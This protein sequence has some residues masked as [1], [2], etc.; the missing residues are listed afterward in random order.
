MRSSA[1]SVSR[2]LSSAGRYAILFAALTVADRAMA[3]QDNYVSATRGKALA[4]AGDC[5]ACH[6]AP[7]GKPFAGGLS[8]ATPFGAIMTPNLTPDEA[9]G[10]GRWSRND[11]SRAMHEG[12]RPGGGYLYPAF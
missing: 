1:H 10:I 8:L 11:F 5:V 3:D 12:R 9:T 2:R 4:I 6:T 7:G